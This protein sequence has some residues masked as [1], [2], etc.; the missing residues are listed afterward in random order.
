MK[1]HKYVGGG[2]TYLPTS[3]A[4]P[5]TA[6]LSTSAAS[7]TKTKKLSGV[8][9]KLI[10]MIRENGIDSD[11]TR[12]LAAVDNTLMHGGG[13]DGEDLTTHDLVALA[14]Q[15]SLVK[16]NYA[17]YGKARQSLDDQDAW[18]EVA[19]DSHGQIYVF[20]TD[21]KK[22]ETIS[23]TEYQDSKDLYVPLTNEDLMT[24]RRNNS[25]L[26]YNNTILDDMS[27][28]VGLSTIMDN[29]KETIGR[30]KTTSVQGYSTKTANDIQTGLNEIV[31][32]AIAG[33]NLETAVVA[34]P[35]GIYKISEE[36]TI[37][38]THIKEAV[39]YL[40]NTLPNSYKH[41]LRA[42]AAVENYDPDALLYTML[43]SNT[44]RSIKADYEDIATKAAGRAGSAAGESTSL[45]Q[46]SLANEVAK[47]DLPEIEGGVFIAPAPTMVSQT[48]GMHVRA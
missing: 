36:S 23:P 1:I 20:N 44:E 34:G 35:D 45:A 30:F 24:Q 7:S 40:Y 8:A 48:A 10:D 27:R 6:G 28:A 11:V 12:F 37:A 4:E 31:S 9:D 42:K 41:T 29:L 21:S 39:N 5:E 18:S 47:G 14:R 3:S 38:D 22:I 33:N 46:D 17:D 43:V 2:I 13:L 16:T 26:S 25:Q 19:L 15:A 32:G